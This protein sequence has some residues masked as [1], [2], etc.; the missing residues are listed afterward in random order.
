VRGKLFK[1]AL[2][3]VTIVA[4]A[5]AGCGGGGGGGGTTGGTTAGAAGGTLVFA[6]SA[7][8][9]ALDGIL[10]SDGES[11]RVIEQIFETL[12]DLKPGTTEIEPALAE[13][14]ESSDD[15]TVWTFKTRQGVKFQDG[16]D[17]NAE[18]V[19]FNFN[20]WYN[21]KGSFQNPSAT[22]YW[23]VVFGGFATFDKNSGAPKDSLFKS[24]EATDANTA[25]ITL[26]KPSSSFL[27]GLTLTP[28]SIGSPDALQKY[29]ADEG[30]VDA[31]GIFHP[32]GTYS[33]QHPIGT[34]PFKFKSWTRGDRLVIERYDDYWGKTS[35]SPTTF[36]GKGA[37]LDQVIFKPIADNAARLQALQ[38]GEIQ[39][40]DLV[41]PQ[42]I[43]TIEG[44]SNLQIL[45][46]PPFN[47]GY[48]GFSISTKPLD[49]IEVRKAI[50]YGLDRQGVID[51]F[52]AGRGEVAKEFMPSS[53]FGYADDVTEY[54]YDP[55]KS[56]QIL[57]DA[58]Y[59]LPVKID[60]WY[61]TDVSRPYMPDPKRN[62]EAFAASLTKAGFKVVPHSAPW[63]PDYLGKSD[64][65]QLPV[66]LLGWTGDFGDPD[67]FIGVFF[68][69]PQK[70]WGTDKSNEMKPVMDILD[71]AEI[72]TDE[73]K[74]TE[75]YQEANRQIMEI[76]PGVPY[77]HNK[78]ALAFIKGIEGYVP[79]P[80]DLQS[81]AT[82]S[83]TK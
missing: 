72:E 39:G 36:N 30:E 26:T 3:L 56:K 46:R 59:T 58:G 69:S 12:V 78:P 43:S 61:P 55:E 34:G 62:F 54:T 33:T 21:F 10:V 22:Y 25:V 66:Y 50:A 74:R 75:L 40:Y 9:V 7:D 17:F 41:E 18:A 68:Q 60:F 76:L 44:D 80:V 8:P 14:W 79:S 73:A 32:T 42:D 82:V 48:V 81:F 83:L 52:Y 15:G 53:L 6:S 5:A 35:D 16:T 1:F 47:V 63:S 13:S 19:C 27:A 20:R 37:S 2:L 51:S 57:Q 29:Q 31:D 28:F 45:D 4:L 23:Q 70:Q 65:G 64:E 11:S 38:T 49:D 24:C 77:A 71:Q 67:D